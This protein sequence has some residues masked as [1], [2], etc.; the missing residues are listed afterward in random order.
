MRSLPPAHEYGLVMMLVTIDFETFYS[1]EVSLTKMTT[2]EYINHPQFHVIG[3]GIKRNGEKTKWVAGE[4]AVHAE[5]VL[6]DWQDAA[7]LCHNTMFDGAIL[8]WRFGIRPAMYLDTLCMARALHGVNA[9]GSLAA[10]AE[11]YGI[12]KKGTE[13]VNAIGKRYEDFSPEELARYGE[14]CVNDTD[15]T[16]ALLE[17]LGHGFPEDEATLID[18]TI[19]MFTSPVFLLD[20]DML[21]YKLEELRKQKQELLGDLMGELGCP[22]E[23]SVRKKLSSNPQFAE[24]LRQRGVTVP[25]KT[26]PATGRET[27]AFAKNDEGFIALTEHEDPIVQQLCAV[28]LGTKS[29]LEESRIER[30]LQVGSRNAGML[31]VPL[32]YYGA[33]TGRW[34]GSEGVNFQNLPSRDKNKKALKNAVVPPLGHKVINCDSSQIEARVLAWLAGQADVVQQFSDKRDVYSEFAT[35]VYGRL[36]SKANPTERFV[37]K[38]CVLGLGYGTGAKKLRHTLATTPPGAH[39]PEEEC[40]RI[41]DLYRHTNDKIVALWRACDQAIRDMLAGGF[42]PYHLDMHKL[43]LIEPQGVKLPNG[44][45]IRYPNLRMTE[46]GRMVYDSRKG[47]VNL[48]GGA[49]VENIV[50]ALARI[51]VGQQM[52][53]IG[54]HYRVALTVHDAA[55]IVVPDSELSDAM[56]YV[57]LCMSTPPA[58]A[59]GLPVACE[60]KSGATYGA[61]G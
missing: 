44:L 48:W 10:L 17:K 60:A 26:S 58:W 38:T 33:H 50:Q 41:V 37:G 12:G 5:L 57:T 59:Q 11:R 43:I 4:E 23:E 36:I 14:Y 34:S 1:K 55:V 56:E 52:I 3:M 46:D 61:C 35:K 51:V 19:R 47:L 8:A 16:F 39:L 40:K 24:I 15:L 21:L 30:F 27:Y 13:V 31:P 49:M 54:R 7:L 53:W 32:K 2:E 28:R 6:I 45:Y 18:M 25:M 29:T 20:E 22:D 42:K 9:G